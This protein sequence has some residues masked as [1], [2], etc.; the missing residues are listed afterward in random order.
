[1][2]SLLRDMVDSDSILIH[3]SSN[4]EVFLLELDYPISSPG[5]Y[6]QN[7]RWKRRNI[8]KIIPPLVSYYMH[9]K[10]LQ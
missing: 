10:S 9:A 2:P 5:E 7:E 4:V 1:M 6:S 3:Q 8:D